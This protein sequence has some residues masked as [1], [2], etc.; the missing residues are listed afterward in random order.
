[1]SLLDWRSS[2]HM[3]FLRPGSRGPDE[4]QR[5]NGGEAG[6]EWFRT[7]NDKRE[8][9]RVQ[10]KFKRRGASGEGRVRIQIRDQKFCVS[11]IAMYLSNTLHLS[12]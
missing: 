8:K 1:M 3:L 11:L 4:F 12:P 6:A 7:A 5:H 2:R 10:T 9:V